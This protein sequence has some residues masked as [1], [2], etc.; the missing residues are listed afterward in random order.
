M[1]SPLTALALSGGGAKGDFQLGALGYLYRHLIISPQLI[2]GTSVGAINGIKLAEGDR[3]GLGGYQMGYQGLEDI[4][5]SLD[6]NQDMYVKSEEFK[7]LFDSE[8]EIF[9][10]DEMVTYEIAFTLV[11]S[12]PLT[13]MWTGGL[14]G[15]W[16]RITGNRSPDQI[17][18]DEILD[19]R[20]ARGLFTLEPIA[21]MMRGANRRI[22]LTAIRESPIGYYAAMVSLNSGLTR[23]CSKHG[24]LYDGLRFEAP[25]AGSIEVETAVL[26]SAAIPAVFQF[27]EIAGELYVDGGVREIVPVAACL[28]HN[29]TRVFAIK[30]G[31]NPTFRRSDDLFASTKKGRADVL[32][33]TFFRGILDLPFAEIAEGDVVAL[34]TLGDRGFLVKPRVEVHDALTI[35]PGLIRVNFGYGWMTAFDVIDPSVR[36]G[37]RRVA[38]SHLT[39]EI[40]AARIGKRRLEDDYVNTLYEKESI[41][42]QRANASSAVDAV[43]SPIPYD[44]SEF[45]IRQQ[46]TSGRLDTIAQSL[47]SITADMRGLIAVRS[48]IGG[49]GAVPTEADTW[50]TSTEKRKSLSPLNLLTTPVWETAVPPSQRYWIGEQKLW[51][52]PTGS[53]SGCLCETRFGNREM[54]LLVPNPD[55]VALQWY[56]RSLTG[57]FTNRGWIITSPLLNPAD[58][59]LGYRIL[60]SCVTESF[61]E[62]Y[63]G[64]LIS[65]V[66]VGTE[67]DGQIALI[68]FHHITSTWTYHGLLSVDGSALDGV[69]ADPAMFR[70]SDGIV[71]VLAVQRGEIVHLATE[72]S[73]ESNSWMVKQRITVGNPAFETVTDVALAQEVTGTSVRVDSDRF[74]FEKHGRLLAVAVAHSN[75][76]G[77][78]RLVELMA[79]PET[80]VWN[81]SRPMATTSGSPVT[82]TGRP[83]FM[84]SANGNLELVV[85][86]K[87]EIWA[88]FR[89]PSDSRWHGYRLH[90]KAKALKVKGHWDLIKRSY[91]RV[92]LV[93]FSSGAPADFCMLAIDKAPIGTSFVNEFI[94]DNHMKTWT[95]SGVVCPYGPTAV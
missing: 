67:N 46:A 76:G 32:G 6:N 3:A 77:G 13:A 25:I 34:G 49:Q 47:T 91:S 9:K 68:S 36:S 29:A 70:T 58:V 27:Q 19:L 63:P 24:D 42:L 78:S 22:D 44:S 4:W 11:Q 50:A 56:S 57:R 31:A 59:G 45:D 71:H 30:C 55:G 43:G 64:N 2:I 73:W 53:G 40:T 17:L 41:E 86:S 87:T 18:E 48:R 38:L 10:L 74:E 16:A 81:T 26:A 33:G 75:I 83:G 95:R 54:T 93:Q 82:P 52:E 84:Q 28:S 90:A 37:Y 12:F 14:A 80:G 65:L 8:N 35:D 39:E 69:T 72:S 62:G 79:D 66:R 21:N 94:M 23:Y 85:P 1:T 60:G 51:H 5:M 88:Y 15:L 61:D 7:A 89:A 20:N 92:E